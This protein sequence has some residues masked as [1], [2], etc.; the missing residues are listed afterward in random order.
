LNFKNFIQEFHKQKGLLV[1]SAAIIEKFGGFFLMLIAL[2]LISKSEFGFFTYANMSL[3]FIIPFVGFGVHQGLV[4]FGSLSTSQSEKKVL[5]F[6]TLRKGLKYSFILV[7]LVILFS[8]ITTMNIKESLPYLLILSLQLISL[9]LYEILRIYIRLIHL[10][11]LYAK[12]TIVKNI[13][14]ILLALALTYNFKGIGYAI[15][16]VIAPLIIAL[17]Y[18]HTLNLYPKKNHTKTNFQIKEFINYGLYMSAGGLLSELLFSIDIL[19][20]SNLLNDEK[21]VAQYRASSI[22]PFSFLFLSVAF[23]RTNFVKLSNKSLTDTNYIKNYYF[24]YLKIFSALSLFIVVFFYFFSDYLFILFG[25]EYTN[26]Y[27]LMFIFSIGV[28]GALLFRNPLA[29]ILSAVGW[30][31]VNA[32]ISLVS[33]ILNLILSYF[34]ILKKGIIGAAIATSILFWVSGIFSLTA[35]TWYLKNPKKPVD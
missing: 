20:I 30:P 15:S 19:L 2:N 10:N 21:M 9:F 34:F 31:K 35:F 18:I 26:D 14:M 32:L 16:L 4:R 6:I 12:I 22:I 11:K 5:L 3:A 33:L 7:L 13:F 1:V 25:K 8:P 23:I 27:N 24:N 28:A 29:N 17:Y